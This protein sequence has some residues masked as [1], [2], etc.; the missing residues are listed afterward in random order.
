MYILV[1][2]AY[3]SPQEIACSKAIYRGMRKK[4]LILTEFCVI[5]EESASLFQRIILLISLGW[6]SGP[7]TIPFNDKMPLA[8]KQ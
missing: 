2:W 5:V 8:L 4:N 3:N 6:R 7:H 1:T